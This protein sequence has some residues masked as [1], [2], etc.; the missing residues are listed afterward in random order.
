MKRLRRLLISLMITALMAAGMPMTAFA[1]PDWPSDTGI[2][3]EAG[4]VMDA[5]SGAVLFGQNIHVQKAPASITK[6]LTALVVIENSS[7]D[8]TI[9][10][11]HDAVYNVEDGSGNK[12]SIEEG[13]TLSV[14][15]CLYLLL[16]RSS[17]QA[18]NALAEHVGGSRDGFVKMMNEKTAELG[19]ENSHFANPSGLNDDTQLT[20]V[21]DM[22]LIASAAY[23]NDT[24]L[25]ISKDKSY[26]LPA[27]K[28]NPDGVTIQPEHKLLITT[29]TESPNYY[30]YAVAGKT[31]YTSIAGQTLV[32][33]AIK[34][35]RRQIAV[36]MKSTQATH[37]QDTIAL[38]DFGFLRFKNVNISENET[39]Y[40]SGD[41]PV[42]I[43][44]NSYQPSDLSMDTL[45]VITLPKDASFADAEKTVVTDL[46]EDAPQGAVALLSYK[47][48]DRKIGQVY[49]ISASA[50]EA[51]AN[52]ETASD[53]GNTASDSAASNTGAS[54]KS[55]QAKSSFH[56]TLPKL[57][58]V[59]VR[60]V[61]IVVVSVL[62]AAA[63]AA[64]VWLFYRRHQ[65]EKRRQE[66]RRKRR[67]QR[68]QEIGCS[69]EEFEKLLEK[70]MGASYWASGTAEADESTEQA[71]SDMDVRSGSGQVP[72][73][74][75]AASR[76][77]ESG[78]ART[79][80]TEK[81]PLKE[82]LAQKEAE[83]AKTQQGVQEDDT[84]LTVE[85][86]D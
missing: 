37:Y 29:D 72:A 85:D 83:D 28:N 32:T 58:K 41:Q 46:P 9:T 21:Y 33:Y 6:I 5:D 59:S 73:A 70:R 1:K 61:L 78:K 20:S 76:L 48:N 84:E 42:Q 52:G 19:C 50:A 31:G 86:L 75:A 56:L 8:D 57:P 51:E 25:T 71:E 16:M 67:R 11:S 26:R 12:N 45:A 3:S 10:F 38:M 17:N 44:D 47:Y 74:D 30:P 79:G 36:T 4:I 24:L 40:T 15:D 63:C 22:A 62:L 80:S 27:T 66:D 65:E 68:L 54:G 69:Q 39:A 13:D 7:L 43:G 53:D 18:A 14:R 35:D 49:L 64:L 60:T 2:E 23:K 77:A 81:K 55:K 34:D 82:K